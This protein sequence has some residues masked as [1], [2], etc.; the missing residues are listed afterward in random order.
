MKNDEWKGIVVFDL[1]GT[2]LCTHLHICK[3]VHDTLECLALPDVEDETILSHIEKSTPSFLHAI[4]PTCRDFER[5]TFVFRKKERECLEKD[6]RLFEGVVELLDTLN[7]SG[8]QLWICSNGSP[9]YISLALKSTKIEKY[10]HGIL[11]SRGYEGK[12]QILS[13][14][15]KDAVSENIILVGDRLSDLVAA[16]KNGFPFIGAFYGYGSIEEQRRMHFAAKNPSD[17]YSWIIRMTL[18]F[19]IW[20]RI[21]QDSSIRCIGI[22]GIDTSGKSI[23]ANDFSIFLQY[24]GQHVV[25]IHLDD[26]HNP[27]SLRMQGEN[28][29]EAYLA[30]AFDIPRLIHTLL[31]PLKQ[32]GKVSAKLKLLD[33]ESDTY[34]KQKQYEITRNSLVILE[35]VLL[36]RQPLEAFI[37]FK[38]YLDIDFNEMLHRASIR[39]V[40]KFGNDILEKYREKYIPVQQKYQKFHM[41]KEK[42]DVVINN[43]DP[44]FPYVVS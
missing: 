31:L 26:F 13:E 4:A 38:I 36:Y 25:L 32:F 21:Q 37:D 12:E 7:R 44:C 33:L 3:A 9:E 1:D 34:I 8:F 6:G 16:Q 41:P 20:N 17:I 29:V 24:K 10:F 39:D 11:S 42:S 14:K 35:G 22:N 18:F 43:M 5:L 15:M 28:E 2:L 19:Q 23:F 27:K 30:N 40:P